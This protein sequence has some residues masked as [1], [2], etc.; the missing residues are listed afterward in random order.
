MMNAEI[1]WSEGE[2]SNP[3]TLKEIAARLEVSRRTLNQLAVR[4]P[5]LI[6]KLHH[7]KYRIRLDML[8]RMW[9]SR[10]HD[11]E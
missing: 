8:D 5:G 1:D 9:R 4:R 6:G 7:T 3:L 10:F 2:W 11:S